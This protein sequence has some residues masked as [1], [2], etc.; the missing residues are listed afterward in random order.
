[1]QKELH[2]ICIDNRVRGADG[3]TRVVLGNGQQVTLPTSI[4]QVPSIL[5]MSRGNRVIVNEEID[6]YLAEK[7]CAPQSSSDPIAFS[8]DSGSH[9]VASD[10][11]SFLDMGPDELNSKGDGGTRQMHHYAAVGTSDKIETP[12]DT[13]QPG[14]VKESD[15]ERLQRERDAE[16]PQP[17][18][19][20]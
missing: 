18:P 19:R 5:L 2:F 9:G 4:T 1:M 7:T 10:G 11:Y 3:S 8:F 20:A 15:M 6:N 17:R 14:K 16:I 12:P 13:Y